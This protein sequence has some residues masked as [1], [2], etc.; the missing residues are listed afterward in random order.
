MSWARMAKRPSKTLIGVMQM[1]DTTKILL[2]INK[3]LG[4]LSGK[5]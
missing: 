4:E 2:E 3:A 1:D 5:F